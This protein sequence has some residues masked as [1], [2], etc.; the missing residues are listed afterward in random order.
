LASAQYDLGNKYLAGKGTKRDFV[1]ALTWFR[2]AAAQCA[3]RISASPDSV[4]LM[5][6]IE[7]RLP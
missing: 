4:D 7:E 1:K 5:T 6:W 3:S 2:K